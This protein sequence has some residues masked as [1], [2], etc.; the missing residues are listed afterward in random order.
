MPSGVH[1]LQLSSEHRRHECLGSAAAVAGAKSAR[2]HPCAGGWS[3][4]PSEPLSVPPGRPKNC[5]TIRHAGKHATIVKK[6]T[7]HNPGRMQH[8][9]ASTETL[10]KPEY[11]LFLLP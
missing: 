5:S 6:K 8:A 11:S 3:M 7:R 4:R 9:G 1:G 2:C 10:P